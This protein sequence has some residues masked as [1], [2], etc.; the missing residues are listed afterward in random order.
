MTRT[1]AVVYIALAILVIS[2]VATAWYFKH[3]MDK[4][5]QASLGPNKAKAVFPVSIWVY[6]DMLTIENYK[7]QI[8]EMQ[9][10]LP[11]KL[12]LRVF[13]S[14][15]DLILAVNDGVSKQKLPDVF[16][17]EI[18]D[19][20]P[21]YSAGLLKPLPLKEYN[22]FEWVPDIFSS[23]TRGDVLMAFPSEF[24]LLVLYYNRRHFDRVGL[25]YPDTHWNWQ[26]LI[27]ISRAVYRPKDHPK[28][29]IYALEYTPNMDIWNALAWQVDEGL[30][31]GPDW[32]WGIPQ[33]TTSILESLRFMVDLSKSYTFCA[34][35]FAG[36]IPPYFTAGGAAMCF[37]GTALR[38]DLQK[39][40]EFQWGVTMLPRKNKHATPLLARGWAVTASS[41]SPKEAAA[42]AEALSHYVA[43]G[44]MTARASQRT[45]MT[46]DYTTV[47]QVSLRYAKGPYSHPDNEAARR[48]V[49]NCLARLQ[50][51]GPVA[52]ETLIS[53]VEASLSSLNLPGPS[54]ITLEGMGLLKE[55][56]N[57]APVP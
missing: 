46:N 27:D 28:G 17:A 16:L 18:Q 8:E 20:A 47:F 37:S 45:D 1:F 32:L 33:S 36:Q 10:S 39:D 40:P 25:A 5:R 30:Y 22:A 34:P 26:T 49:N 11:N 43:E 19:F 50:E 55:N 31:R 48:I 57:A 13:P 42:V 41:K 2:I 44:W 3:Q 35:P 53:D 6:G 23:F 52:A 7:H 29:E 9:R 56:Q 12:Q 38:L 4:A 24:S 51:P 15:R 14:R 54:K 21:F